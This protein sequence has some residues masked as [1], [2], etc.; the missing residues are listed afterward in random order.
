MLHIPLHQLVASFA[1]LQLGAGR[2]V[3]R[4]FMLKTAPLGAGNKVDKSELYIQ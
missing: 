1:C 4:D 2:V 3:H